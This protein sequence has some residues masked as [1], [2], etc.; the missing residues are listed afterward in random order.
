MNILRCRACLLVLLLASLGVSCGKKKSAAEPAAADAAA[1]A[2]PAQVT[3]SQEIM[4]ALDKKDYEAVVAG[5]VKAKQSVS[6]KD[7]EMAVANLIDDVKIRLI[8]QA[9]T[10]PKASEALANLRRITGG[11]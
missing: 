9:P 10:D 1:A 2:S 4:A 8:E 11:R 6:N 5:I 3:A 7:E